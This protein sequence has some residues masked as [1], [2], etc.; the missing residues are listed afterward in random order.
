MALSV[1]LDT[2]ARVS[3]RI[4]TPTAAGAVVSSLLTIIPELWV[5]EKAASA[6]TI[7]AGAR[8]AEE[9][10][11]VFECRF[12]ELIREGVVLTVE[13]RDYRVAKVQKIGRRVGLTIYGKAIS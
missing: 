11:S 4:E 12:S 3:R 5:A 10:E 8:E 6:R 2:K 13:G 1:R 7:I 9:V